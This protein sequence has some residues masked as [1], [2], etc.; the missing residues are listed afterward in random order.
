MTDFLSRL[1]SISNQN[2]DLGDAAL[3][4]GARFNKMQTQIEQ[5]VFSH[6]DLIN[7]TTGDGLG[8]LKESLENHGELASLDSKEIRKL[9]KM[10]QLYENLIDQLK[11]LQKHTRNPNASKIGVLNDKI[12]TLNTR[13]MTQANNIVNQTYKTNLT[14]NKLNSYRAEQQ[15]D[16]KKKIDDLM[17]RKQK[18]DALVQKKGDLD[19]QYE[20][21]QN[22]LDTA[23]LNYIAW[24]IAATTLGILTIRQLSK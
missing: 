13:I 3:K 22:E 2:N 5:P 16:L 11:K 15:T 14:L 19:G 8:S 20:N 10:E 17:K 24:F 1:F 4:Q 21:R 18:Y 6:L 23:Y 9:T 7:Q 12:K